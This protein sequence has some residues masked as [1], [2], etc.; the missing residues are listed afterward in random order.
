[1]PEAEFQTWLRYYRVKEQS[2]QL[3]GKQAA[4]RAARSGIA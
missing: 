1:M 4:S 2:R 3:A